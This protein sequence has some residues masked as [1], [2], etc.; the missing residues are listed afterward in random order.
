[1]GRRCRPNIAMPESNNK[2]QYI[3]RVLVVDDDYQLAEL[4]REVLT[5]ENCSADVASNGMEA[6]T[7]L[8][9]GDYDA[10]VSDLMMPR[11]DG[12]ALYK[13]V[14]REFPYLADRFLFMTTQAARR[15]GFSDFVV[16]TGN[17]LLE[18]PFEV[19]QL[20]AA[21]QELLRRSDG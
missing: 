14:V 19:E 5:Y 4:L 11:L 10:V 15:A 13:D 6:M 1:M 16:R 20:R 7:L 9:S 18:K 3:K 8:R 2:K 12:E 17:T 21:L